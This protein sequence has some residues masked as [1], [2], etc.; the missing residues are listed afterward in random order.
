MTVYRIVY[1]DTY[2]QT[3]TK[4]QSDARW[5]HDFYRISS[6]PFRIPHLL[7]VRHVA[8]RGASTPSAEQRDHED[9]RHQRRRQGA[10]ALH[11][12]REDQPVLKSALSASDWGASAAPKHPAAPPPPTFNALPAAAGSAVSI[13]LTLWRDLNVPLGTRNFSITTDRVVTEIPPGAEMQWTLDFKLLWTSS[14]F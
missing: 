6:A 3:L 14:V 7:W 10:G 2:G 1:H 12:P 4:T 5:S 9:H 11:L 13:T 8:Q